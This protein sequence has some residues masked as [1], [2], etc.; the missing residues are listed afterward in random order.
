[1][2][3]FELPISPFSTYFWKFSVHLE[4]ENAIRNCKRIVSDTNNII[5]VSRGESY[6]VFSVGFALFY[7]LEMKEVTA[8]PFEY[9]KEDVDCKLCLYYSNGFC[10]RVRCCCLEEKL[11]LDS[12]ILNWLDKKLQEDIDNGTN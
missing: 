11:K 8:M 1:M 5:I 9:K 6:R 7:F 10:R 12:P 3:G 2:E 4:A